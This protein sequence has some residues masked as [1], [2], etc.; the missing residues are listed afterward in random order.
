VNSSASPYGGTKKI[1]KEKREKSRKKKKTPRRESSGK[2]KV[3]TK[4]GKG[5]EK[6]SWKLT[7]NR[8]EPGAVTK[9]P[10]GYEHRKSLEENQTKRTN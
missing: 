8:K 3:R 2:K 9:I 6:N 1:M 5:G 10:I 4:K 7:I